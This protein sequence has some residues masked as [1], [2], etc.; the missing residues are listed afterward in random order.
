MNASLPETK[1]QLLIALRARLERSEYEVGSA[2]VAFL[3]SMTSAEP[4]ETQ[5]EKR[6]IALGECWR[7]NELVGLGCKVMHTSPEQDLQELAV[8]FLGLAECEPIQV[9]SCQEWMSR[10]GRGDDD[11]EGNVQKVDA[12]G[13]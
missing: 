3:M 9:P 4:K 6:R 10:L 12:G 13:D 8:F 7:R 1:P 11:D 5:E 2:A